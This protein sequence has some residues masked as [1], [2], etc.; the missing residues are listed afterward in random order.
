MY[1]QVYRDICIYREFV[2][3][4]CCISQIGFFLPFYTFF[5]NC[6]NQTV[7]QKGSMADPVQMLHASVFLV[8]GSNLPPY[9]AARAQAVSLASRALV[10]CCLWNVECRSNFA[11]PMSALNVNKRFSQNMAIDIRY[12]YAIGCLILGTAPTLPRAIRAGPREGIIFFGSS[13]KIGE[14]RIVFPYEFGPALMAHGSVGVGA[15]PP[16]ARSFSAKEPYN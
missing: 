16:R 2:I 7:I 10:F 14:S 3:P 9:A 13:S 8:F 1:A 4:R 15:S 12:C 11:C 5:L 6:H